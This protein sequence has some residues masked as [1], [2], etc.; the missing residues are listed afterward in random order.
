MPSNLSSGKVV[1]KVPTKVLDAPKIKD[2]YYI[3]IL[4]WSDSN[5][6]AVALQSQVYL[7]NGFTQ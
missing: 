5:I 3:N 1:S 6:L 2:D 7:W 4:D